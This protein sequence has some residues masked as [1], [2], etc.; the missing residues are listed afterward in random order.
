MLCLRIADEGAHACRVRR[1]DYFDYVDLKSLVCVCAFF[2]SADVV[3]HVYQIKVL[4]VVYVES[5]LTYCR[6][7]KD[8]LIT[9]N[10]RKWQI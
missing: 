6:S 2:W 10:N 8:I 3:A 7:Y 5:M 4:C 1:G 9:F